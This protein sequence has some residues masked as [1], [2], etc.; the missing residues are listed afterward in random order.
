MNEA[1]VKEEVIE[2]THNFAYE[3]EEFVGV[4]QEE[5]GEKPE[6]LLEKEIKTEPIDFFENNNSDGFCEG[7]EQKPKE[8]DFKVEKICKICHKRMPRNLLRYIKLDDDK[9]VVSEFFKVELFMEVNYVCL[10]HIQKIIDDNDGKLKLA[11]TPSEKRLRSFIIKNKRMM[12]DKT[13]CRQSCQVC[14]MLEDRSKMYQICSKDVRMVVMIGCILRGTHTVEQAMSYITLNKGDTCYSHCKESIEMIFEYLEVRNL[15]EF[16]KCPKPVMGGLM[17][18]VKNI[19][20]NFT[21]DQFIQAFHRLL[22]KRR[23]VTE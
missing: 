19:D 16:F 3:D 20:S 15:R 10:S 1:V 5:N 18:I 2:E 11:R 23:K 9:T 21:V 12:R 8:C 7:V 22:L 14:Y 4:K 6:N 17:D 13:S